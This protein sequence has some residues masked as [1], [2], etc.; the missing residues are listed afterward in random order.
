MI[1]IRRLIQNEH[2]T[3]GKLSV[4]GELIGDTLEL[5]WRNNE[6]NISC[7][8]SAINAYRLVKRK[9]GRFYEA[10]RDR[11]G[12]DGSLQIKPVN[13]RSVILTHT[14]TKIAHTRGCPLTGQKLED[15]RL[16]K[17]RDTYSDF[18]DALEPHW[19]DFEDVGIPISV[20]MDH[21][22][23]TE[24]DWRERLTIEADKL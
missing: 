11:W 13:G 4:A 19:K 17:S 2:Y 6:R 5:P 9:V 8:P 24:M 12:H 1:E 10:Y 3:E 7:I 21:D 20:W 16:W 15:G 14:G 23:E 18:W 22:E